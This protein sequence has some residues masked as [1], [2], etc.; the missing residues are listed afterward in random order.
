MLKQN[1]VLYLNDI[2][3][4]GIDQAIELSILTFSRK[5]KILYKT[6]LLGTAHLFYHAAGL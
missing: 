1:I 3:D 5:T 4:S 6:F 2:K